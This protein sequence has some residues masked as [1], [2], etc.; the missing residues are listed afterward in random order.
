MAPT[1]HCY[2]TLSCKRAR[3]KLPLDGAADYKNVFC[4][5]LALAP[6]SGFNIFSA[7]KVVE[8]K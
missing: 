3:K 8:I 4:S 6:S 1:Q 7:L 5:K 2:Y